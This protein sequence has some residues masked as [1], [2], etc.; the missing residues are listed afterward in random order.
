MQQSLDAGIAHEGD[1]HLEVPRLGHA[2]HDDPLAEALVGHLVASPVRGRGG[3][4]GV[5][6]LSSGDSRGRRAVEHTESLPAARATAA[7]LGRRSEPQ[8]YLLE[9]ARRQVALGAAPKTAPERPQQVE[10][11]ARPCHAHVGEATLP[12]QLR[13]VVERP[14]VGEQAFLHARDEDGRVFEPLD[15]MERDQRQVLLLVLGEGVLVL[16]ERGALDEGL[17]GLGGGAPGVVRRHAAELADIVEPVLRVRVF[18]G[19]QR[20]PVSRTLHDLVNQVGQIERVRALAQAVHEAKEPDELLPLAG[21][22]PLRAAGRQGIGP[23][24]REGLQ[25]RVQAAGRASA[26]TL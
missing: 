25:R 17:Q 12:P 3:R 2:A 8:W 1:R 10:A 22:E 19:H 13:G 15:L 14:H 9:E 23:V 11:L 24:S 18:R 16:H 7:S 26:P 5:V 20:G 4:D 6:G 21:A